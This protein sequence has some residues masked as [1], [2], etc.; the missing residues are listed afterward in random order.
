MNQLITITTATKGTFYAG[1]NFETYTFCDDLTPIQFL[2]WYGSE[3]LKDCPYCQYSMH[4][5]TN[6][7]EDGLAEE[8]RECSREIDGSRV[9]STTIT[10][11]APITTD[12]ITTS[13][14]QI[15]STELTGVERFTCQAIACQTEKT[16][17][18][19]I[20]KWDF[21]TELGDALKKEHQNEY[22]KVVEIKNLTN[23]NWG[24]PARSVGML[25]KTHGWP[26]KSVARIGHTKE[27][28]PK[29]ST[30]YR[31]YWLQKIEERKAKV[32]P[33]RGAG[34]D[35]ILDL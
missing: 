33:L 12:M 14:V 29:Q 3:T 30:K 19:P 10:T 1:K 24:K 22:V 6:L 4:Y 34:S 25:G 13:T 8:C 7:S 5:G 23:R 20:A 27:A 15:D 16:E 9:E 35:W 28:K 11:T 32:P 26:T 17:T 31:N 21:Q 2:P 18:S